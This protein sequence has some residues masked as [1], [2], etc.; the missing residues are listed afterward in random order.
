M[1][2]PAPYRL[3]TSLIGAA[4]IQMLLDYCPV[5]DLATI[6]TPV[7]VLGSEA[8]VIHPPYHQRALAQA[9]PGARLRMFPGGHFFPRVDPDAFAATASEFLE[10]TARE[11][12]N[13]QALSLNRGASR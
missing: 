12:E 4:R 6:A 1:R 11:A 9:I 10:E 7:L 3:K 2:S 13:A 5:G 8:D